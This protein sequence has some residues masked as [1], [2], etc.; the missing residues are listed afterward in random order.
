MDTISIDASGRICADALSTAGGTYSALEP[1]GCPREDVESKSTLAYTA[2]GEPL[3]DYGRPAS[4]EDFDF[5]VMFWKLA[6]Q[7]LE[8]GKLK[9][10]PPKLRPEGLKGILEGM[11]EMRE[12]KVSGEKLVYRIA[13]TP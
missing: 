5:G 10:H 11:Q 6:G 4:K 1:I 7:L 13:D 3:T 12:G 2:T 9:V 8:Q